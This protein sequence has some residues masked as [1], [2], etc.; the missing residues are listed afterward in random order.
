MLQIFLNLQNI[1][2]SVPF[3]LQ[4]ENKLSLE[5]RSGELG[6][7]IHH[8]DETNQFSFSHFSGQF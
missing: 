4:Y 7:W 1:I 5:A 2:N 6:E 3:E 8:H